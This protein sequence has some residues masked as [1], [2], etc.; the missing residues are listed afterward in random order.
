MKTFTK[1]MGILGAL[2]LI[3]GLIMTLIIPACAEELELRGGE[4]S[5]ELG[6]CFGG[7]LVPLDHALFIDRTIQF[8]RTID[9]LIIP[10]TAAAVEETSRFRVV[11]GHGFSIGDLWGI[12]FGQAGLYVPT[13]LDDVFV[14]GNSTVSVN[15]GTGSLDIKKLSFAIAWFADGL[16]EFRAGYEQSN[17]VY[18]DQ[19]FGISFET[20]L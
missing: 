20:K 4:C 2:S 19:R 16:G 12:R 7:D 3:A 6:I 9:E 18:E 14:T 10:R 15:W 13:P 11:I 5:T 17:D 1:I 8:D